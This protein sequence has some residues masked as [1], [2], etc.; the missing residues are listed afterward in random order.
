MSALLTLIYI[1][2][3]ANFG[4]T[5]KLGKYRFV[6]G[7]CP[8]SATPEELALHTRAMER[9]WGAFPEGDVRIEQINNAYREHL[10]QQENSHGSGDLSPDG[11][12]PA[13]TS[14]GDGNARPDG[15][16][17]SAGDEAGDGEGDDDAATG[18]AERPAGGDGS[19]PVVTDPEPVAETN[20]K[21]RRAILTLSP[22]LDSNWTASGLPAMTAVE[23]AYGSTAIT[24][25]D[26]EAAHPGYTRAAA[27]KSAT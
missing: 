5:V 18:S 6:D 11:S 7:R 16:E 1:L 20:E 22:D 12:R 26:V 19:P 21:L 3:G 8:I 9:N 23:R 24:R 17:A 15:S 13:G 4:R 2:T 10:A 14:E 27:S 25:A